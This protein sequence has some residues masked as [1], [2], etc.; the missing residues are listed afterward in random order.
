MPASQKPRTGPPGTDAAPGAV[1]ADLGLFSAGLGSEGDRFLRLFR[2]APVPMALTDTASRHFVEAND[3]WCEVT[4]YARGQLVGRSAL[5]LGIWGDPKQRDALLAHLEVEE[6]ADNFRLS[7]RRRDGE[8]REAFGSIQVVELMGRRLWFSVLHDVTD[9]T[10]LEEERARMVEQQHALERLSAIGELAG[11]VA[12]DINNLLL[13]ILVN[14]E[15]SL[16]DA[17]GDLRVQLEEMREAALRGR[18]L[19]KKLLAFG[20]KQVLQKR[21]IDVNAVVRSAEPFLRRL[22]PPGV[23]LE[24]SLAENLPNAFVDPTQTEQVLMNL[25]INARQAIGR[26]GHVEVSTFASEPPIGSV[27]MG[28]SEPTGEHVYLQVADDGPGIPKQLREKIFEPFFTTKSEAAGT[29]LGLSTV[30]GIVE[31]HAGHVFVGE[32]AQGGA[33]VTIGLPLHARD[34]HD[35]SAADGDRAGQAFDRG[36][37]EGITV[38]VVEDDDAVRS[39]TSRVLRFYGY[40]VL[41]AAHGAAALELI[42][43]G[44]QSVDLVVTD[45][46]MPG[47][48]G[49]QLRDRISARP[50][51]VPVVFVS[52]YSW[53]ALADHGVD[54][55]SIRILEKPF[56]PTKLLEIVA[57]E[58]A[59]E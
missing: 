13:P 25:V 36:M 4:G 11:G 15:L 38:L 34:Q 3:R 22:V 43:A 29:G 49:L 42:D 31:Q 33:R 27:P 41:E 53:N 24:F 14:A 58:L 17:E 56:S 1:T 40:R 59:L 18:Q 52:G 9:Q 57:E 30:L 6:L 19:T 47:M 35:E 45:I 48:T 55:N 20:R 21:P 23:R 39:V 44:E 12:H 2:A 8:L 54:R 26:D 46:V 28:V 5:E 10:L 37:G 16:P 51:A 32:S 50:S 7:F